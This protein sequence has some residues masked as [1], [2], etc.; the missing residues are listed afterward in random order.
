VKAFGGYL[1]LE[2]G[3]PRGL[4][5]AGR[6]ALCSGRA[7]LGRI[8]DE[9]QPRRVHVPFYVCD[10]LLV[11]LRA[12]GIPVSTYALTECLEPMAPIDAADGDVVVVVN[13]FG[14]KGEAMRSAARR[15][16][17]QAVVDDTHAF[18][19]RG[20]PEAWSFNSARK[21]F[22]VAD[23]G[24]AFGPALEPEPHPRL[25]HPRSD[26]L[27]ARLQGDVSGGYASYLQAEAAVTDAP[28]GMSQLSERLLQSVDYDAAAQA[29]RRNY[30]QVHE[31][32]GARNRLP[33]ALLTL[34]SQVPYCYPLLPDR[35][36]P[37]RESLW[38]AGLF[39]PV[40]WPE[41]E[42]R[43][44]DAFTWEHRLAAELLPLPID[45]RYGE[46]DIDE[47][48]RRLEEVCGW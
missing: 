5:H 44:A 1:E 21:F 36:A 41:L 47:L 39:I 30:Q 43:Q 11:P 20:Y 7:C 12:R 22:G 3:P 26:H 15:Y 45:H 2:V 14:L 28:L 16:R 37:A 9:I 18:F 32:F 25:E 8:L 48:C 35:P 31:R 29:R 6:L 10:A 42:H 33:G 40:L 4:Y 23:G 27:M 34:A 24:Y 17:A 13:Y 38:N 19:A 46:A